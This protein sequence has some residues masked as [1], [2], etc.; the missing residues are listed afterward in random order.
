MNELVAVIYYKY[1]LYF[2][3]AM[4]GG[5]VHALVVQ[6]NGGVKDTKDFVGLSI[7]SGF[8]GYMWVLLTL[9]YYPDKISLIA[10]AAGFGGYMS[11]E[12]L[13]FMTDII[14]SKLSK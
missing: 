1:I 10:F 3:T 7:I 2:F 8:G 14:K 6:R 4:F 9:N 5:I 11:V 13:S 12:G